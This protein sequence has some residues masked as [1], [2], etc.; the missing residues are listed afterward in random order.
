[1]VGYAN[2]LIWQIANLWFR[3]RF[4]NFINR[5]PYSPRNL[6][7]TQIWVTMTWQQRRDDSQDGVVC[8]GVR[9]LNQSITKLWISSK[10][11]ASKG[12]VNKSTWD[13]IE[14]HSYSL[15]MVWFVFHLS[16][17]H[18]NCSSMITSNFVCLLH[19]KHRLR[20]HVRQGSF[21]ASQQRVF[22]T[23]VQLSKVSL[24][25]KTQCTNDESWLPELLGSYRY[26]IGSYE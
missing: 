11:A 4:V 7:D 14:Y 13:N 19:L 17:Y 10:S 1:M 23:F 12:Q 24:D 18:G 8:L 26:A 20:F 9:H 16:W 2:L 5:Y 25:F 6:S 22:G 3:H 21:E 15:D